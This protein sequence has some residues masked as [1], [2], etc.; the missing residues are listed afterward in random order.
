[1]LNAVRCSTYFN[2]CQRICQ[3]FQDEEHLQDLLIDP[4]SNAVALKYA[5]LSHAVLACPDLSATAVPG[6][7]GDVANTT[8]SRSFYLAAKKSLEDEGISSGN[9]PVQVLQSVIL[10][11]L[12]ELQHAEFGNAWITASRAVW[13]TH[14]HQ[15]HLLDSETYPAAQIIDIEEARRALWAVNT[16][17]SLLAIGGRIMDSLSVNKVGQLARFSLP[18][19]SSFV[20]GLLATLAAPSGHFVSN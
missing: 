17:T 20:T 2:S 4:F 5:V 13:L 6:L 18:F 1:V 10:I 9:L 8:Y 16:L 14:A 19:L 7:P 12:Y 15:L 11:G 3:L